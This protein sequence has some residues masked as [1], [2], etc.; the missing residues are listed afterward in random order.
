MAP[1]AC[2]I[3]DLNPTS[4]TSALK[5]MPKRKTDKAYVLDRKKH[6]ARLNTSEA[7]KV[8][9]KRGEGKVERQYRMNCVG[10]ELVV[11][12]R[13]EEDL[14]YVVDVRSVHLLLKLI[15]RMLLS[16]PAYHNWKGVL[17]K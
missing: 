17:C 4:V 7:G 16:H 15:R 10:C 11:C 6:L 1:V 14:E 13:T 12:Y 2:L 8:L 9:L 3:R 5:K